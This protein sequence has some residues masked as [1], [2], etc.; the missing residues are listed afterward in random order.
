MKPCVQEIIVS[1]VLRLLLLCSTRAL[2][3]KICEN[4]P[5]SVHYDHHSYT[6]RGIS[7]MEPMLNPVQV[8][9]IMSSR[10]APQILEIGCGSGH[11]LLDLQWRYP[12]A[13]ITGVNKRGYGI[14]QLNATTELID[15][16]IF[17][18]VSLIC[19]VFDVPILPHLVLF[20]GVGKNQMPFPNQS[21]DMII[22]QNSLD[23]GKLQS[24][25]SVYII[26]RV[27]RIL[28]DDGVAA[29]GLNHH[30]HYLFEYSS[31]KDTMNLTALKSFTVSYTNRNVSI[32]FYTIGH[33]IAVIIKVC[34]PSSGVSLGPGLGCLAGQVAPALN[35]VDSE[36]YKYLE[37]GKFPRKASD[38]YEF[39]RDFTQD[40]FRYFTKYLQRLERSYQM[41]DDINI[42]CSR[43]THKCWF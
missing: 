13:N 24:H 21:F 32:L 37:T 42:F 5:R 9:Q 33:V 15:M 4:P 38:T 29:L 31:I 40:Y 7:S 26:S 1:F 12:T 18:N 6:D 19:D 41:V 3:Y 14:T 25:E 28:K 17:Y 43:K 39:E 36:R 35:V 10:E 23:T 30:K 34:L 11:A 8:L 22:S 16:S 27:A 20:D 2:S